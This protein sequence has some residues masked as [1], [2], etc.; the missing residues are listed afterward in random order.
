MNKYYM[1]EVVSCLYPDIHK[2]VYKK[3]DESVSLRE[4]EKYADELAIEYAILNEN[5]VGLGF[6]TPDEYDENIEEY[7]GS[8]YGMVT[9]IDEK[10]YLE[11]EIL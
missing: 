8:I 10:E 9:E 4:V 1:I 3:Y 2:I 6:L 11:N 5:S 7:Y